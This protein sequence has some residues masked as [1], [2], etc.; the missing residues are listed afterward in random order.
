MKIK[1]IAA[2]VKEKGR[3][4]LMDVTD[5]DGVVRQWLSTGVACYPVDGMPYL[6]PEHLPAVLDLSAKQEDEIRIATVEK[7]ESIDLRDVIKGETKAEGAGFA[8][9]VAGR[10]ALPLMVRGVTYFVDAE[11]LIPILAEYK[12]VDLWL[13][14]DSGL[15]YFAVKVGLMIVG[16]VFPM[17]RMQAL[18]DEIGGVMLR[19]RELSSWS[20]GTKADGPAED[21]AEED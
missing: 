13:R 15:T 2:Q 18:V 11:L 8:I 17:T 12:D 1:K 4:E 14:Q 6:R 3:A 21:E 20:G 5:S 7:P 10:K 19:Y 16:V 9:Y